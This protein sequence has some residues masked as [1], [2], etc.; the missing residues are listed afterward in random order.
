M[1]LTAYRSRTVATLVAQQI[2]TNR[3]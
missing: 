3:H 2:Y 1:I